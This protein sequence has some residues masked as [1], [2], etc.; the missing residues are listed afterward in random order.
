MNKATI[1]TAFQTFPWIG[2]AAA[3]VL[4][5]LLFGTRRLRSAP[6]GSR[7]HDP[8]WLSWAAVVAYLLH[9]VEEYGIDVFGRRLGFPDGF[10]AL[11]NL[12]A[13]PDCPIPPL[14]FMAVN[15]PLFWVAAPIAASLSRRHTLVGL[16]FYS[17]IFVNACLH[18][19]P[20]VAGN[21]YSSGT[22]TAIVL[23][24]PMSAWI[25]H[26]CFGPGRTSYRAMALLIGLGVAVHVILL[27]SLRMFLNGWIGEPALVLGQLVNPALLLLV[28]WLAESSK[29]GMLL[30]PRVD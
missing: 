5:I 28:P 14:F 15:I 19:L 9:N 30:R 20:F 4:L 13:F 3:I 29:S 11:L 16:A 17:V 6:N 12:P 18:I 23:F 2:G 10:C 26:A 21:G 22:L 1:D 8:V 7:W 27:V 25:A 24:V